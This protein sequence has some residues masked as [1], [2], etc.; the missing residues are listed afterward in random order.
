MKLTEFEHEWL[1][2]NKVPEKRCWR[3]VEFYT[4]LGFI[5]AACARSVNSGELLAVWIL[6]KEIRSES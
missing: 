3:Y 5:Y 1:E 2:L 6:G 4:F